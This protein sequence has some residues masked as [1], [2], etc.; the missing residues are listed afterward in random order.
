M[1]EDRIGVRELK[2]EVIRK[3]IHLSGLLIPIACFQLE[4]TVLIS[5]LL[6]CLI[7]SA[8]SEYLRLHRSRLFF[9]NQRSCL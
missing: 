4:R 3:A 2:K 5:L 7:I 8:T 6:I 1:R 9:L